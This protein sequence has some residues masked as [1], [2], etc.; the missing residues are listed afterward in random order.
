MKWENLGTNGLLGRID[1]LPS[2]KGASVASEFLTKTVSGYINWDVKYAKVTGWSTTFW[3]GERQMD[4]NLLPALS[5]FADAVSAQFRIERGHGKSQTFGFLDH[6]VY[7]SRYLFA[8]ELKHAQLNAR[9][10]KFADSVVGENGSWMGSI[11]QLQSF[12][13]EQVNVLGERRKVL[14]VALMVSNV[15]ATFNKRVPYSSLKRTQA[16]GILNTV[17]EQLS[18]QPNWAAIWLLPSSFRKGLEDHYGIPRHHFHTAVFL[19]KV[20]W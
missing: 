9:N 15:E 19:S 8:I 17:C 14:R 11:D 12:K 7:Y 4:T 13:N 16:V 5:G 6:W 18:P 1:G 10:L 2:H 3:E 20:I